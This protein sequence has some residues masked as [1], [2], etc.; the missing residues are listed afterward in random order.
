MNETT[1]QLTLTETAKRHD[2]SKGYL[3]RCLKEGRAAK[4]HDLQPYAVYGDDGQIA[5]F[6][7][8]LDYDF[9]AWDGE[10]DD[11]EEN[12]NTA[13]RGAP[14]S[15]VPPPQGTVRTEAPVPTRVRPTP[16][17]VVELYPRESWL[18]IE[19]AFELMADYLPIDV[20][21]ECE[22]ISSEI[23]DLLS[24]LGKRFYA[25][26]DIYMG[27]TYVLE[28][29]VLAAIEV[30]QEKGAYGAKRIVRSEEWQAKVNAA[31]GL[32][33]HAE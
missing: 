26:G 5:H 27:T 22:Q 12:F 19:E 30:I 31:L 14:L 32:D 7:F 23:R 25:E 8:P 33:K 6:V 11:K 28:G 15:D 4:G 9:P 21:E 2:I 18:T 1:Q 13:A 10:E 20:E 24:D 3:S 17:L 29:N 16:P